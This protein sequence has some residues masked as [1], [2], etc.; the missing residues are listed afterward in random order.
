MLAQ[1][2]DVILYVMIHRKYSI[3]RSLLLGVFY[4]AG[5][6][7]HQLVLV[8]WFTLKRHLTTKAVLP[9]RVP[10]WQANLNHWSP[11]WRK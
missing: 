6:Q 9:Q 8:P 10:S 7:Q 3:V 1:M 11:V 4:Q 2:E 5:S